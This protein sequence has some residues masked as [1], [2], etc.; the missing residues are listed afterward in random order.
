M[1]YMFFYDETEHSRKINYETVTANNYYDNF[2]TGIVGWKAE[3]DECI[4]DR[5]LAFESKYDYRKKDGELKSQTMKVKDFRLGFASLNNHTIELYEDL[6]SLFDEKIIIYFSV[7]SKIEYVISQL[8]VNYHNSM[9]VDVDYMK[10]SIIKAINVYRPQN[11][12]EAI[13]KEPQI[14]VKELRSFLEDRIIKNQANTA[15]K[16]HEN[17]AFQEILLLLEDTEVPETLDWSYFAPFDGFKKLLTE[18]NVN[19]YQL[20][21]DRE[22]KESHTLNSA[23]DAGLENVTEEDSKDY[24][25][26]RMADLLVGLIS[27][28]MQSL[29]KA[30]IGEYKN[31]N[32]KKTLLDAGWFA[33]NQRQLD[34]Y[35]KLHWLICENNNYWYKS[36]S[37]IYSDDLVAFVTLLQFKNR[38]SDAN[39]IFNSKIEMQPEYYNTFVCESLNQHYKIMKNKLPIVPIPEDDKDYFYNQRGAMVYKD[40]S[41]QS[42]L[43]LCRGQNE[44]Y[45]LSVGF[46][47]NGTPLVTIAENDK[48][49]C[50]RLP[51]DY[52]E[53]AKDVIGRTNT[54]ERLFPSKVEFSLIGGRYFVD[55]L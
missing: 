5:Y 32:I 50:Y 48:P 13:Y 52:T 8:F 9:F 6:V 39:A 2:I 45:V 33:L 54:G 1:K 19:E 25:G 37:G 36:F 43:P 28:L 4:S 18:M 46:S 35:K 12:I 23:I 42:M 51:G 16:E 38:F 22:G 11:V 53:W 15:L 20:V 24:V 40:I 17:Q 41:K 44:F 34:L 31:G 30:L 21:I 10:Y 7:F 55:I 14:F 29:K 3:D 27:R 26:I 49:I 47:K